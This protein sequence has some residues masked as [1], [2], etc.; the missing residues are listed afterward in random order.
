MSWVNA[1]GEITGQGIGD[2]VFRSGAKHFGTSGA[3]ENPQAKA[4]Q[5]LKYATIAVAFTA[6]LYFILRR[7]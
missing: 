7:K 4:K 1:E 2:D 6:A 3:I 5:N